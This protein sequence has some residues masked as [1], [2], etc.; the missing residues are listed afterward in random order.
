MRTQICLLEEED[1]IALVMQA[2]KAHNPHFE[3]DVRMHAGGLFTVG[4]N[5]EAGFESDAANTLRNRMSGH[6]L[7]A[8][9][10]IEIEG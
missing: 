7:L 3:R 2:L 4:V 10:S 8:T 9:L 5:T 6:R 1:E